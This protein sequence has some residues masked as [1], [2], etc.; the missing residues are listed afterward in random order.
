[1]EEKEN[2]SAEEP[3]LTSTWI[4]IHL[5]VL[6]LYSHIKISFNLHPKNDF[7]THSKLITASYKVQ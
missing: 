2:K 5:H 7:G 3:Q 4:K 6:E 1:M